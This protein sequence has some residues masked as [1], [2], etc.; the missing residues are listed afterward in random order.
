M[1]DQLLLGDPT[2]RR[3]EWLITIV[4][5]LNNFMVSVGASIFTPGIG[6][7]A[8]TFDVTIVVA[9]LGLSL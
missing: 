5:C 9:T 8:H 6:V 3:T 1:N 2:D 7:I 4:F